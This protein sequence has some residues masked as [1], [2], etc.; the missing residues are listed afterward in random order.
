MKF[1]LSYIYNIIKIKRLH[2][3]PKKIYD[4]NYRF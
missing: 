2:Y 1:I 4:N 3:F